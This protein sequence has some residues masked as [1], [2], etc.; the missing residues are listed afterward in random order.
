MISDSAVAPL[1]FQFLGFPTVPGVFGVAFSKECGKRFLLF[2]FKPYCC[3]NQN[4]LFGQILSKPGCES[5]ILAMLFNFCPSI[6]LYAT[7]TFFMLDNVFQL[8]I[9]TLASFTIN[10][11][12][13][14]RN[15][16][17]FP[18]LTVTQIESNV[19][20]FLRNKLLEISSFNKNRP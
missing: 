17:A 6:N 4:Q 20:N 7:S 9:Y 1:K 10:I 11:V 18:K 13:C 19:R 5:N 14:L 8:T 12:Q 15:R 16:H 3:S 2:R